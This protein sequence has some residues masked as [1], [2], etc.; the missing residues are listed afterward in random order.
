M[1]CEPGLLTGAIMLLGCSCGIAAGGGFSKKSPK[2][3][4]RRVM[5]L[6]SAISRVPAS[7]S[8][9]AELFEEAGPA[10]SAPTGPLPVRETPDAATAA[11]SDAAT[12]R[13]IRGVD[14]W[15]V[16]EFRVEQLAHDS[17]FG[18]GNVPSAER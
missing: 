14:A 8:P 13:D 7:D 15:A 12:V 16:A 2:S 1:V 9:I 17:R 10:F 11:L 6:S 4:S 3:P 5:A 18:A